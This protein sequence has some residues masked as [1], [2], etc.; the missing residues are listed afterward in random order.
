MKASKIA[1]FCP[2][3]MSLQER[4]E[5]LAKL[6]DYL[7]S[8]N[9]KLDTVIH[10][11]YLHNR[12]LTKEN[13]QLALQAVRQEFLD[14]NKLKT[15]VAQYN[16]PKQTSPQKI[17][18]IL[19]GNIPMVGFQDI[20]NVFVAGHQSLIKYSEKDKHLIPHLIAVMAEINPASA[21]Y[22]ESVERLK[23][24]DAVI[25][26]GSNNSA[27]YF[28]AYFGKYPHIIRK[29]RTSVAILNGNETEDDLKK[30]GIDVFRFFGLGCRNVSKLYVPKDYDFIPLL[31]TWKRFEYVVNHDKYKSNFDY[32]YC[33]IIMN[34]MPYVSNGSILLQE[35]ESLHSRIA[36]LYYEYYNDL[37]EVTEKLQAQ[38]QEIQCIAS[39]EGIDNLNVIPFGQAQQP[40]LN[41][42][43]DG[44]DTM[45]FLNKL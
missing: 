24:F 9:E 41:D 15:W 7:D 31:E 23:D 2:M 45:E 44:V 26:T 33:L 22:F 30:L 39:L 12:W 42:Y 10:Q 20:L 25:A 16:I 17:G 29:N 34:G 43:A 36:S 40:T 4:V 13:T 37:N 1:Y 19:A 35:G 3:S 38:Q 11:T 21:S 28:E 32:N 6:G 18:L 27:R 8:P 5:L 14:E